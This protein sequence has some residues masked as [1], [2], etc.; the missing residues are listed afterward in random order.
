L[1]LEI[2]PI[3]RLPETWVCV[4]SFPSKE[5]IHTIPAERRPT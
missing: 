2:W 3:F 4:F 5:R 1:F